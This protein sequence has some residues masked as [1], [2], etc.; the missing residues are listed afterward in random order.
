MY[1]PAAVESFLQQ[2]Q[3]RGTHLATL[4]RLPQT[5]CHR[6]AQCSN[7]FLQLNA[8]GHRE[9]V[10]IDWGGIGCEAV[11]YDIQQLMGF[12]LAV[13]EVDVDQAPALDQAVF[14]GYLGGLQDA[15]WHGDPQLVR[16]GY[17]TAAFKSRAA[18]LFRFLPVLL[19]E[20][21]NLRRK[22]EQLWKC[23]VEEAA[24]RLSRIDAFFHSLVHEAQE[25][26]DQL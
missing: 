6:D 13:M 23:S 11:G 21:E 1:S 14:E 2:W 22:L 16:L 25:L 15:G 3:D 7:L 8:D 20:D 10:A 26:R 19:G 5:L 18:C 9:L 12:S 17:T 4:A 24:N